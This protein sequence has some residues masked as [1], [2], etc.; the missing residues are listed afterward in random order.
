MT[1]SRARNGAPMRTRP[2]NAS[3]QR[4]H[5]EEKEASLANTTRRSCEIECCDLMYATEEV[6][7]RAA[8]ARRV[9]E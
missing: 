3:W 4:V 9:D 8:A 7:Q 2:G 1:M 5:C 6:E